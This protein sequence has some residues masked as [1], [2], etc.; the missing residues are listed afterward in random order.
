MPFTIAARGSA[1]ISR[2]GSFLCALKGPRYML[3]HHTS[4]PLLQVFR[5]FIHYWRDHLLSGMLFR[6][7]PFAGSGTP[8]EQLALRVWRA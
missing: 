7:H 5:G 3:V 1:D 8:A 2:S 4:A 6:C